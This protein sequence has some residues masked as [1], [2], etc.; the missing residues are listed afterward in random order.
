[1][2]GMGP[3]ANIKTIPE[4]YYYVLIK[5]SQQ[6][7]LILLYIEFQTSVWQFRT[8]AK[9]KHEL[10]TY[11]FHFLSKGNGLHYTKVNN[12]WA[13]KYQKST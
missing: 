12:T 3:L 4:G 8:K 7:D 10:C 11:K 6:K 2:W 13:I 9:L 1:M 5:Y